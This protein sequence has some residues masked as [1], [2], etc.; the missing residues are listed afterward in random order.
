MLLN[1]QISGA[2]ALNSEA[3]L[4]GVKQRFLIIDLQL[5]NFSAYPSLY[6]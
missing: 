1:S 6:M 3:V 5:E 4:T 2:Q